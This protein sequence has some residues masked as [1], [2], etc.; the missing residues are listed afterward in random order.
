MKNE[1]EAAGELRTG[2]LFLPLLLLGLAVLGWTAFQTV[3][4]VREHQ[5]L[6]SVHAAQRRAVDQ[7]QK[8]RASLSTMAADTQRLADGGDA[9]A[10]LIVERLRQQGITINPN[11]P[12]S[13]DP[14]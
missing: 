6:S 10:K 4:L 9:G 8:L 13:D 1:A 14:P 3:E 2:S 12:N 5:G 11:A 7:S